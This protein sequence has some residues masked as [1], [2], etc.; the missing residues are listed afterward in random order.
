MN[1]TARWIL[2]KDVLMCPKADGAGL[3]CQIS[4]VRWEDAVVLDYTHG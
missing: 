4:V 1:E 2:A 3:S